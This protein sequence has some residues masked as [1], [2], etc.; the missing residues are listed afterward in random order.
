MSN[1]CDWK[2]RAASALSSALWQPATI[3]ITHHNH[4]IIACSRH[5]YIVFFFAQIPFVMNRAFQGNASG[6]VA[7]TSPPFYNEPHR[8][9]VLCVKPEPSTTFTSWSQHHFVAIWKAR[10][11]KHAKLRTVAASN[12][13]DHMPRSLYYCMFVPNIY[14][15]FLRAHSIRGEPRIPAQRQ[16]SGCNT[17]HMAY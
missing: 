9:H 13:R 17:T 6:V 14:N 12:N 10:A 5:A 7:T 2:A 15:V 8:S 4:S 3:E 16:R 1:C 11:A